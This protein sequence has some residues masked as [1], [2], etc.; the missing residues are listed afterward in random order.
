MS[1][2]QFQQFFI[3][4]FIT[5]SVCVYFRMSYHEIRQVLCQY[6]IVGTLKLSLTPRRRAIHEKLMGT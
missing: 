5:D 6:V 2:S 4:D 3:H 1:D